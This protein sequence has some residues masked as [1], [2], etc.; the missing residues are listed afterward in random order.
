MAANSVFCSLAMQ[1]N[2]FLVHV[3]I[4]TWLMF[5]CTVLGL[6][7]KRLKAL[8]V[9][10]VIQKLG[11]RLKQRQSMALQKEWGLPPDCQLSVLLH[12]GLPL[13]C[14]LLHFDSAVHA[15]MLQHGV[16]LDSFSG[17]GLQQ[18]ERLVMVSQGTF[19]LAVP[20][21]LFYVLIFGD[22]YLGNC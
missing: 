22:V 12:F 19:V 7:Y 15:E 13:D 20:L 2:F 6:W 1:N 10:N 4:T 21:L 3:L 18:K 16:H 14:Q 11:I 8:L 17:W 5:Q 9:V